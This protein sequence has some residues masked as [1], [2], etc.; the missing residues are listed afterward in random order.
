VRAPSSC[1]VPSPC[2]QK[3]RAVLCCW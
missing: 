1:S 3:L 2:M